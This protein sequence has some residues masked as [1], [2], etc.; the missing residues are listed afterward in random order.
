MTAEPSTLSSAPF[1]DKEEERIYEI[2]TGKLRYAQRP[3][4]VRDL[5]PDLIIKIKVPHSEFI[6]RNDYL[7]LAKYVAFPS[8]K[9]ERAAQRA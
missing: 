1:F 2:I 9:L 3:F 7:E 5:A 4:T 8:Q 6:P